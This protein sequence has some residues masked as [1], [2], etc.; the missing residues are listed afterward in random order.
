[1]LAE[2]PFIKHQMLLVSSQDVHDQITGEVEVVAKNYMEHKSSLLT[3]ISSILVMAIESSFK[4]AHKVEWWAK[5]EGSDPN[6][7]VATLVKN[8]NSV[9][10]IVGDT[11]PD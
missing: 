5:K 4:E 11:L 8:V 7:Y 1:M 10:K 6:A 3:K 2:I 9:H